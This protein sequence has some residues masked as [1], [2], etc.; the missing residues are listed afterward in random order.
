MFTLLIKSIYKWSKYNLHPE[1]SQGRYR[2]IPKEI[3]SLCW[4]ET[5]QLNENKISN[6]NWIGFKGKLTVNI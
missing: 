4:K 2:N 3:K 1:D 6:K 5:F